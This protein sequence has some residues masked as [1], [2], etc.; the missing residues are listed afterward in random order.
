MDDVTFRESCVVLDKH[1]SW[2]WVRAF[3]TLK[4]VG[5]QLPNADV[6]WDSIFNTLMEEFEHLPNQ[7]FK[8]FLN[9]NIPL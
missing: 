1:I 4:G 3:R 2:M 9:F 5:C 6:D 8:N 7:I